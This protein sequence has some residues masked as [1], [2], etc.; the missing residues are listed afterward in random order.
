MLAVSRKP[1]Q[2]LGT[3]GKQGGGDLS[4]LRTYFLVLE[5]LSE[6]SRIPQLAIQVWGLGLKF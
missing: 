3:E 5:R 4:L 6:L 1:R 2:A